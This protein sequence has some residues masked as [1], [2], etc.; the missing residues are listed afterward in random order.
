M[1]AP[2]ILPRLASVID[3]PDA[4]EFAAEVK[5]LLQPQPQQ[6]P[7]ISPKDASQAMLNEAKAKGQE[8][9]NTIKVGQLTG[10]LPPMGPNPDAPPQMGP[11]AG[12]PGA[13][14]GPIA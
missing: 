7:P 3:L 6:A 4:D 10:A 1:L 12:A 14:Q 2:V 13:N 11:T 5:Q 8:I 9:D